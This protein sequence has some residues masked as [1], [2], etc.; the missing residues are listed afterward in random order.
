MEI[1]KLIINVLSNFTL[2]YSSLMF[3]I[4]L[5]G[6]DEKAIAKWHITKVFLLRVGIVSIVCGSFFNAV[7]L[8][9]PELPAVLL[10]LG[11]ALLFLWAYDFHKKIFKSK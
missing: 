8:S 11:L 5:F 1:A 7:T 6:D 9:N 4:Y 10:N 2:F 3:Y